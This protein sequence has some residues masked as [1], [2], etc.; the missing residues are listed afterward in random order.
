MNRWLYHGLPSLDSPWLYR[1]RPVWDI[2]V[3]GFMAGGSAPCVRS[4][5]LAWRVV[6]HRLMRLVKIG[7]EPGVTEDLADVLE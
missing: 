5:I 1:H 2:V 4:L 3:I 7:R 6:K